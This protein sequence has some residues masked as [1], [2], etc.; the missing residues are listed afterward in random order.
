VQVKE[1]GSLSMIIMGNYFAETK[2][3]IVKQI[4]QQEK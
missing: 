3:D 2:A 4:G 1:W